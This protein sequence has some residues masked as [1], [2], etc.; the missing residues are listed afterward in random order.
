MSAGLPGVSNRAGGGDKAG[1]KRQK[2]RGRRQT[3]RR[4]RHKSGRK[5]RQQGQSRDRA[6]VERGVRAWGGS[7]EAAGQAVSRIIFM[8]VRHTG[9]L[10]NANE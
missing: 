3:R 10:L 2:T 9:R 5:Q 8:I 7:R 1:W 4:N 6:R